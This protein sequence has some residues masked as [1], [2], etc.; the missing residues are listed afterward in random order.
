MALV[1]SSFFPRLKL[2][3]DSNQTVSYIDLIDR[4]TNQTMTSI[5]E[6]YLQ[7]LGEKDTKHALRIVEQRCPTIICIW[8]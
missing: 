2:N 8:D 7:S 6:G 3:T 4:L 5:S 1:S